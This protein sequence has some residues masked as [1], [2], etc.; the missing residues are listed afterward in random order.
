MST[1]ES[2]DQLVERLSNIFHQ[3][4]DRFEFVS[5]VS[6]GEL[7]TPYMAGVIWCIMRDNLE[8]IECRI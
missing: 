2:E 8:E 6:D 4:T 7:I 5:T 3:T 1:I